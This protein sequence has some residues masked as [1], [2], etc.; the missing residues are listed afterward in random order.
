MQSSDTFEAFGK[1][2]SLQRY[3]HKNND[4]L[5]A[6]DAADIYLLNTLTELD[7]DLSNICI[8]NDNFGAL[9]LPLIQHKPIFYSDSWLSREAIYKNIELNS[10]DK[11]LRFLTQIEA[12]QDE[13]NTTSIIIGR[14]PKSKNHLAYLLQQLNQ[15][16]QPGCKLLLAGMDKH[17]SKGQYDL[18]ETY[19]GPSRFYPG[20]KKA[21]IWEA[22]VDKDLISKALPKNMI[23]LPEFELSL[24]NQPNVFSQ[25][26]LDIGTRFL[27]ENL[28]KLPQKTA[29]ADLACGNGTLGLA[30]LRLHPESQMLF[31]DE[32]FQAIQSCEE[33]WK[34]NLPE[35]KVTI[36][37]DDGLKQ[38]KPSELDL[39]LCNPPF[40]QQHILGTDIAFSLFKDAFRALKKGGE[41]WLVANRHLTYPTTLKKLF[42]NCSTEASNQKFVI[43]KAVKFR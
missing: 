37:V 20:V 3:P 13:P 36:R 9:S 31:T 18:V 28:P 22:S 26:K 24:S 23:S 14:V 17:L 32:S 35:T 29:V 6:W 30:Y 27:L 19:F 40:H 25:D 2:Y 5:R 38:S 43:L 1:T 8:I 33:N 34:T 39:V 15:W 4:D 16:A 41:F 11:S 10:V 12:L 7:T 42:G 21:R